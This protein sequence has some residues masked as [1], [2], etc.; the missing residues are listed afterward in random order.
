MKPALSFLY[1]HK[2]PKLKTFTRQ[3]V[4]SI[5]VTN[6]YNFTVV[7]YF[8]PSLSPATIELFQ[9]LCLD[10]TETADK[11]QLGVDTGLF[12]SGSGRVLD[13]RARVGSGFKV[14]IRD[15]P[16]FFGFQASPLILV[17]F[18]SC[19]FITKEKKIKKGG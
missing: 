17:H 14:R 7:F 16:A 19:N 18:Q 4:P 6:K 15:G 9:N 5:N 13:L 2:L 10:T 3:T 11:H 1:I 8:E 12:F